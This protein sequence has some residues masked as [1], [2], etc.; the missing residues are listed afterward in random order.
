MD[1]EHSAAGMD[2]WSPADFQLLSDCIFDQLAILLDVIENGAPW[3]ETLLHTKASLQPK[4][5]DDQYNPLANRILLILPTLY[6][7][8][9]SARHGQLEPWI[10]K[11]QL[12]TMHAGVPGTGAEDAWYISAM[13]LEHSRTQ[14]R[15]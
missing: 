6:R 3:P 4:D 15:H 1:A 14:G 13:Q 8:W 5:P 7:R 2:H 11:W 10:Q 12:P 9:A